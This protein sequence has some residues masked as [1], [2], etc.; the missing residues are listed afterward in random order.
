VELYSVA[1]ADGGSLPAAYTCDADGVSPPLSWRGVPRAAG[2]LA[3]FLDDPD[4]P[5]GRFRHWALFDIPPFWTSIPAAIVGH[6]PL[7]QSLNDFGRVGYG[8]PCP[9]RGHGPHRYVFVL[10]ALAVDRLGLADGSSF[11]DVERTAFHSS[12]LARA[13][14]TATVERFRD[15]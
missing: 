14:L 10:L 13:S 11:A 12:V 1:F 4:A 15:R 9:P 8:A 3:I 2:S 7:R 6:S 5:G